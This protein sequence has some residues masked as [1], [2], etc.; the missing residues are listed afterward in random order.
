[1]ELQSL[2]KVINNSMSD[3]HDE[4]HMHAKVM[5]NNDQW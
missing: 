5:I 3:M 4:Q 1:M 2:V